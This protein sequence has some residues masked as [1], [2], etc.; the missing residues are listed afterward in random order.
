MLL[1]NSVISLYKDVD[2]QKKK[3][4]KDDEPSK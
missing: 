1:D 2:V 3:K 4:K